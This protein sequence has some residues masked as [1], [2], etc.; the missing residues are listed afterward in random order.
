MRALE[1]G[2]N[3]C[4]Y[5]SHSCKPVGRTHLLNALVEIGAQVKGRIKESEALLASRQTFL[6]DDVVEFQ[7][8]RKSSATLSADSPSKYS[9]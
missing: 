6:L 7:A 8:K 1:Q 9:G 5:V 3:R 4:G 2:P